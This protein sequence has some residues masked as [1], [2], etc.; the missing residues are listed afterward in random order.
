MLRSV[1][2][3]VA[4]F[5]FAA[6]FVVV[7]FTS[8][9]AASRLVF[10]AQP[11]GIQDGAPSDFN[12][13][14]DVFWQAWNIVQSDFYKQPLDPT[15]MTYGAISG[16]VDSLG[17]PH[18]AFVDPPHA[19][20]INQDLNGSF[21]GIGANVEMRQGRLTIV[22]PIRGSPAEKAGLKANDII[23]KVGDTVIQNMDVNQAVQLIRGPKG[24]TV[25]LQVQ[26]ANQPIFTVDIV[27][28]TIPIQFV[29]ARMI[30]NNIA[31]LKL[32][33]FSATAPQE[34]HDQLQKLLA[35]NPKAIILDLRNNPGGF[36]DAAVKIDSEFLKENSLVLIEKDKQGT[37]QEY[38]TDNHGLA[39]DPGIK[40]VLLVNEGSASAS[41]IVSGSLKDY[42]RATIIGTNT[43]GKGS[44]Q[45]PHT[46]SDQSQLRVT[47]AH[48]FSPQE[49][50]INGVGVKPDI[51]VADP[52]DAQVTQ[53][54]DPQLD[55]AIQFLSQ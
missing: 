1:L 20:I 18:T 45:S 53:Q 9:V 3:L 5:L 48:F 7:M 2:K 33:E 52:T 17:D 29:D 37:R 24:T 25:H 10:H 19:Q 6:A 22:T 28:D 8:G 32:S 54:Q 36:L 16:M 14:M 41:E 38:R 15:T 55:R 51:E 11:G 23:L 43:Y 27:R 30:N 46:L 26:R 12:G 31:Y 44:V 47:I 21:E 42:Q 49:H 13:S 40:L 4:M 50:E 39:T 35:N 34:L